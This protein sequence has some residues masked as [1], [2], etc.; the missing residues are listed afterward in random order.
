MY[1]LTNSEDPGKCDKI[2]T[3]PSTVLYLTCT[4]TTLPSFENSVDPDQ[5]ISDEAK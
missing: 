1:T 3:I 5:L 2:V 4:V